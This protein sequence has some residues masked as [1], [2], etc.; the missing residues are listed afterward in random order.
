[1]SNFIAIS[2][3]TYPWELTNLRVHTASEYKRR[4]NGSVSTRDEQSDNHRLHCYQNNVA[5]FVHDVE[6][7]TQTYAREQCGMEAHN[8]NAIVPAESV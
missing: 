8:E 6:H 4:S 1:M 3:A 7:N 5:M 2:H